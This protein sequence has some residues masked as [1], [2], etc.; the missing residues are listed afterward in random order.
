LLPCDSGGVGSM[1]ERRS[2]GAPRRNGAPDT[3]ALSATNR[4]TPVREL[5]SFRGPR[6]FL[7]VR[8]SPHAALDDPPEREMKH[9][10]AQNNRTELD[11]C[12][13]RNKRA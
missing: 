6:G 12:I 7:R 4:R 8:Q 3:S 2:S 10:T 11:L 1:A 5:S 9:H 13:Y